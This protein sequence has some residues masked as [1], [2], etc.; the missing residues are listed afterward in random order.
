M[1]RIRRNVLHYSKTK[2]QALIDKLK[3][4]DVEIIKHF[5][6]REKN[7]GDVLCK[8]SLQDKSRQLRIDH[9]STFDP[10]KFVLI[11]DYLPVLG[12]FGLRREPEEGKANVC[13]SVSFYRYDKMFIATF[14]R[15]G[16]AARISFGPKQGF[17]HITLR[18]SALERH[19]V[20]DDIKGVLKFNSYT[21][22]IY[23]L[24]KFIQ[25]V[26]AEL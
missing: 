12:A 15:V 18:K 9:K 22:Y 11:E 5:G 25:W 14:L 1:S 24:A 16:P 2:E 8:V 19:L 6:D 17:K 20:K 3:V 7:A 10:E 26:K 23:E 21:A 13:I 4:L